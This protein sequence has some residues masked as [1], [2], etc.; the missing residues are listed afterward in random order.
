MNNQDKQKQYSGYK[1]KK[2]VAGVV[3]GK[4]GQIYED[5]DFGW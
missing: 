1:R 4:G 5:N 3:K 2:E